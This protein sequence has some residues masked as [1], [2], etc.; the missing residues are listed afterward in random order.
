M[1]QGRGWERGKGDEGADGDG[2]KREKIGVG[3]VASHHG[4]HTCETHEPSRFLALVERAW[5]VC[6]G[7]D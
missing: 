7:V 2:G 3:V 1:F 5:L 6:G 4:A